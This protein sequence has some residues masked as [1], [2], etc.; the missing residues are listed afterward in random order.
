MWN[1]IIGII[2]IGLG[3]SGRF[4]L[5][6]INSPWALVGLGVILAIW[7]GVQ[8]YQGGCGGST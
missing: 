1:L 2:F 5:F 6:G 8:M 4:T 3:L 7:G